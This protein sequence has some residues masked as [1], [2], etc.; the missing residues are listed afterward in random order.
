MHKS[1]FL[2]KTLL[3]LDKYRYLSRIK[4][5]LDKNLDLRKHTDYIRKFI[6]QLIKY[7]FLISWYIFLIIDSHFILILTWYTV[8]M[9]YAEKKM[10]IWFI[11]SFNYHDRF[12]FLHIWFIILYNYHDRFIFL[13]IIMIICFLFIVIAFFYCYHIVVRC[14]TFRTV[15][16]SLSLPIVLY[17][18][19]I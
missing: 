19:S 14:T 2:S 9:C 17:K 16:R 1:N 13:N 8:Y 3:I 11:I 6:T 4:R 15:V 10:H 12:N 18:S 5:V 7:F